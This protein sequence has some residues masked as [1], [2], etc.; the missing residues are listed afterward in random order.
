MSITVN[1][2]Q[3]FVM[4]AQHSSI[5]KAARA[6]A[7]SQSTTSRQLAMLE[8]ELGYLLFDRPDKGKGLSITGHGLRLLP[9]AK[10]AMSTV[11][12]LEEEALFLFDDQPDDIKI[13]IPD[14]LPKL[15]GAKLCARLWRK[16]PSLEIHIYHP[17]L[18]ETYRLI[19]QQ[20]IDF[21]IILSE[22]YPLMNIQFEAIGRCEFGIYTHI[23]HP[24]AAIEKPTF[25]AL[26][27]YRFFLPLSSH[28]GA[29]VLENQKVS[30]NMS[31][32]QSFEQAMLLTSES[33]GCAAL[34]KAIVKQASHLVNDQ[35]IELPIYTVPG[36]L[37]YTIELANLQLYP[38]QEIRAEILNEL[39]Q[40]LKKTDY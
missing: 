25:T 8:D 4:V 11:E 38:H 1:L 32:T 21:G 20:K 39:T 28:S 3:C 23:D 34:P 14:M 36:L 5:S 15:V 10:L 18:F 22:P 37:T 40:I 35:L 30:L 31:Y 12:R 2:W 19:Q 24:A 29:S 9:K 13:A 26:I 16:W 33:L 17:S 6:L 27:P 7:Q